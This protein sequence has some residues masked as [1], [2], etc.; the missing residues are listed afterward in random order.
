MEKISDKTHRQTF[1]YSYDRIFS[2]YS[3]HLNT[4]T[5]IPDSSEYQ[6]L[7]FWYSNVSHWFGWPFK[8]CTFCTINRI[9]SVWFSDHHS[10]TVIFDNQTQIYHLNIR[11]VQYSDGYCNLSNLEKLYFYLKQHNIQFCG[12]SNVIRLEI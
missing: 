11:L 3:N 5:R 2:K 10:N 4:D 12:Q 6:A 9:F 8:Y 1:L 7:V